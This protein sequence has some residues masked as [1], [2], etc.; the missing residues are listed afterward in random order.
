[1][2]ELIV[3]VEQVD[4]YRAALNIYLTDVRQKGLG[5]PQSK[6]QPGHICFKTIARETGIPAEI[7]R[8]RGWDQRVRKIAREVGLRELEPGTG[9]RKSVARRVEKKDG[10]PHRERVFA[11]RMAT[12]LERLK[13]EGTKVPAC[14]DAVDKPY[15]LLIAAESDVPYQI[16]RREGAARQALEQGI[17]ELGLE[18]RSDRFTPRAISY[19]ELLEAGSRLRG[20]ELQGK[21]SA[22]QQRYNARTALRRLMGFFDFSDLTTVG[23]ELQAEFE[24]TV[25]E[26]AASIKK[27][28]SRRKF[29]REIQR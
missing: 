16:L 4:S 26:V 8:Q 6:R 15:L 29:R 28:G 25:R 20:E 11:Y 7:F 3:A 17:K 1:M 9:R 19:G 12:Y 2:G 13:R 10:D 18:A 22:R 27:P 24:K 21:R 5:I 23:I 14:P